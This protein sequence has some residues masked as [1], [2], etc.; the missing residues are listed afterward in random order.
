VFDPIGFHTL[1]GHDM[2]TLTDGTFDA[3]T[4]TS[5]MT[6]NFLVQSAQA[7]GEPSTY[8]NINQHLQGLPHSQVPDWLKQPYHHI[9]PQRGDTDLDSWYLDSEFSDRFTS[10]S[11]KK[12]VGVTPKVLCR[13][14]RLTALLQ[15]VDSNTEVN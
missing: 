10:N 9:R 3:R 14:H 12:W 1:L 4:L 11:S 13:V 5:E 6:Y 7:A 8:R 15:A 2:A